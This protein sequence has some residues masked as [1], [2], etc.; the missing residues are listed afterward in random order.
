MLSKNNSK[1]S[2]IPSNKVGIVLL[3]V[4]LIVTITI[5]GSKIQIKNN[6][7][8]DLQNVELVIERKIGENLK[9]DDED[10]DGLVDWL[11]EFYK[12]D[13]KNADTDGDG[14]KDGEE[15][16][17]D[18]D[19]TI[20]GPNDPLITTKDRV[21]NPDLSDFTPGT[22]TDQA[23]VELFSQY[24]IL[25]RQGEL[26]PEKEQKLVEDISK[27]I[28][29][30]ISLK[31]KYFES[32][33]TIISSQKDTLTSYGERFA[34]V[35]LDFFAKMNEAK[36]LTEKAYIE[37]LSVEYKIYAQELS[38]IKVP[39]VAIEPHLAIMNYAYSAGV[40]FETFLNVDADPLSAIV[41]ITQFKAIS[42]DDQIVYKTLAQ[43]FKNNAI[44]FDTESTK[45]FWQMFEN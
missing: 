32:D 22:I 13:P 24:M 16:A 6:P 37:K 21:A 43:Y 33:I 39:S 26:T 5:F 35:T 19:P 14:T 20:A 31:Q 27:K 40:L 18:R 3:L 23:S 25:K 28:T 15:V 42:V 1:K 2:I 11:E 7:V 44:I 10:Q 8:K 45:R 36:Y 41:I 38:F 34:Q 9:M 30:Q 29:E 17:L 4:V 12:T